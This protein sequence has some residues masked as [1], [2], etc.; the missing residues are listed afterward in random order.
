[1]NE[2]RKL[3]REIKICRQTIEEIE[4]KRSR[5]QSAL[6]QAVLLQEEPDE[7]DVEWFNKY[8]GEITA[9]RNH[10][11]ELQKKLNSL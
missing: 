11:I 9:C 6:V 5:S 2:K 4:R 7:N 3:K 10:M 1:M 8:T